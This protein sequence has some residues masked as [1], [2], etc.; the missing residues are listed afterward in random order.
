MR[1]VESTIVEGQL[2][3]FIDASHEAYSTAIF[4]RMERADGSTHVALTTARSRVA[5]LKA[6]SI[7][8]LELQAALGAQQ[9]EPKRNTTSNSQGKSIGQIHVLTSV[10]DRSRVPSRRR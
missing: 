1:N 5:P 8:R 7:L 2:Y 10:A 6:T 3:V 4:V 9:K